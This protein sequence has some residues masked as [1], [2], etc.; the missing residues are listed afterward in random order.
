MTAAPS[1]AV[2]GRLVTYPFNPASWRAR[3][4]SAQSTPLVAPVIFTN[5]SRRIGRVPSATLAALVTIALIAL[6]S[7]CSRLNFHW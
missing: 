1:M 7:C 4:T 2:A 3:S 6:L 5:R